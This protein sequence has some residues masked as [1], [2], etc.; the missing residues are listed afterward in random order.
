MSHISNSDHSLSASDI[1]ALLD[2][3]PNSITMWLNKGL[4]LKREDPEFKEWLDCLDAAISHQ[5]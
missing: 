5:S 4:R 1:A 3:H 2:K